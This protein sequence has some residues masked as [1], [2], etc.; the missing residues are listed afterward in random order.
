MQLGGA[1]KG[2]DHG[3]QGGVEWCSQHTSIAKV[4]AHARARAHTHTH[5]N[6]SISIYIH[7]YIYTCIY[8]HTHTHTYVKH[9]RCPRVR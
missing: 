3:W 6:T 1:R 9:P 5:T 8:I 7:P 4:Y 2:L